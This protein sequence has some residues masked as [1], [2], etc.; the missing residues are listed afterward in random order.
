MGTKHHHTERAKIQRELDEL[1]GKLKIWYCDEK[2]TSRE[3][4]EKLQE[5]GMDLTIGQINF[6]LHRHGLQVRP[7]NTM[8][9]YHL[10]ALQNREH[11]QRPCKHCRENYVPTSGVQ[12]YCT[13]CVRTPTASD[14]RRIQK[15]GTGW[16]ELRVMLAFQIGRCGICEEKLDESKMAVD[17]DHSTGKVRGLL[18][19]P[20]NLKLAVVEDTQFVTNAQAYL[21]KCGF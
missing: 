3:I 10:N 14:I 16:R 1:R 21:V 15:Y 8:T 13:E 4:R 19:R 20:C 17:H 7:R 11:P 6:A 18:C 9:A 2:L 12:L 5:N